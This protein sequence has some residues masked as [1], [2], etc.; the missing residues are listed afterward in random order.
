M[1]AGCQS[2]AIPSAGIESA[3]GA[4][5]CAVAEPIFYSPSDTPQTQ[6]QVR[7]HN[8]VGVALSCASFLA[9]TGNR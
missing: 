5:F 6:R 2:A 9:V 3:G 8:A 1:L 4:P 7:E